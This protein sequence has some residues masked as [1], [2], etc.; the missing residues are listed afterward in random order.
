MMRL[1]TTKFRLALAAF[2]LL[3]LPILL[4]GPARIWAQINYYWATSYGGEGWDD[5]YSIQQTS[6]GGYV[7][8]G[9]TNSFGAGESDFWVLKLRGDGT[10]QWQK[11]Y[12]GN[13]W[14]GAE[15]IQQTSDGGYVVAGYTESFGAGDGDFWVLKFRE[16]GTV[17]WQKTYGG[18]GWDGADSIQQTS[19]GGYAVAGD[20]ESFGAG[21]G[22][23]W[24]LKLREDGTVQWQKTFGGMEW[25]GAESVQQTS[26]GGYVVAGWTESF[27]TGDGD[28]WALKL[29][30]DGAIQWQKTY[31]GKEWDWAS[32]I[33]Q[34][35]DGGY[36]VAGE[37]ESFGAGDEDFW[38]LKL[39]GDGTVQ[40]QKTFGGKEWDGAS[41]I[42]QTSDGGYA[43]AGDTESFGAGDGDFWVLKLRGD[44]TVQ[45]QKTFGGREWDEARSIRQTPDGGYVVAGYTESFGAGEE[46]V[47]VL[48]LDGDGNIPEC[49]LVATSSAIVGD[50][51]VV[52]VDS[53]AITSDSYATI[54]N[55]YVAPANSWASVSTQCYHEITPTPTP[56]PTATPTVTPYFQI[57]L[58]LI[59]KRSEASASY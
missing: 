46:D 41:S 45:W 4:L 47:L 31:G 42:Q 27:G 54:E 33:Q 17:Q 51:G 40:W 39:R 5:V 26:D 37:T 15:S 34:T 53:N 19:D 14:D 8:A 16:D 21:D 20:T 38:V 35:S 52:G 32:S 56:T 1:H 11:T 49:A 12:G 23:F 9:H 48:K 3:P 13:G 43:V 2:V 50:T 36:V 44:G 18:N 25:D 24:V 58:P 57:Y 55:T 29:D 10:I 30:G 6:D 7:V 59:L 22:D 28:F